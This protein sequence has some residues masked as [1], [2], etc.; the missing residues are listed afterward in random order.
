MNLFSKKSNLDDE[1]RLRLQKL[2]DQAKEMD[3]PT[4][5]KKETFAV[6]GLS[7]VGFSKKFPEMLLVISSQGRGVIDCSKF[8]LIERDY[9]DSWEWMDTYELWSMG[10]GKLFDE[11]IL[12]GGI[13]GGGL[14]F[15][16]K[17][18]DSL[19]F[20]ATQWPIIDLIFEPNFKSIYQED[21]AKDCFKI[22]SDYELKAYGFSY[23][24]NYFITATGSEVNV[25]R[26]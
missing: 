9:D 24:G 4:G 22:F 16:N 18:G 11:K 8:E 12:V 19:Q 3:I 15:L 2:V 25:Y 1:N 13:H 20:M 5:W 7:N 21:E 6:G 10:I 26:K 17:Y 23:D 14:P